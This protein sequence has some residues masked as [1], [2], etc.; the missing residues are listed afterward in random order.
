MQAAFAYARPQSLGA[1]F[2]LLAEGGRIY[3][4][5]PEPG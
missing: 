2:A 3:A 5:G 4:A 1:L